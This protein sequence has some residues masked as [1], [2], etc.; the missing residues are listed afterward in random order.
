MSMEETETQVLEILPDLTPR[1]HVG[2]TFGCF[3]RDQ[4]HVR[5]KTV[6]G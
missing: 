6:T 2:C 1:T 3:P 5:H 4:E